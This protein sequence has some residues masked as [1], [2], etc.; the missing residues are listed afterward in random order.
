MRFTHQRKCGT[1]GSEK[2]QTAPDVNARNVMTE[3]EQKKTG[4]AAAINAFS[5]WPLLLSAALCAVLLIWLIVLRFAP[6]KDNTPAVEY[7]ITLTA[8][9][10][11]TVGEFNQ[12]ASLVRDRVDILTAGCPYRMNLLTDRIELYIPKLCFEGLPV[13]EIVDGYIACAADFK[14][15]DSSGS[16]D[17]YHIID[18]CVSVRPDDLKSVYHLLLF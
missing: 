15:Y 13:Q 10:T 1:F 2:R 17:G 14:I 11:R 4:L 18:N 3:K 5:N 12:A 9:G 6:R 7:H 8:I 16:Y